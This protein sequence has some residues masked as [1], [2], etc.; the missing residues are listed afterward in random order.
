M[1]PLKIIESIETKRRIMDLQLEAL[2]AIDPVKI[3]TPSPSGGLDE[4]LASVLQSNF[5]NTA[6][7]IN[8]MQQAEAQFY[9]SLKQKDAEPPLKP[10]A[11]NHRDVIDVE[12]IEV[13]NRS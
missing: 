11:E 3:A 9:Q 12:F 13:P 5:E 10:H 8:A 2:G 6:N 4:L 7:A 1:N